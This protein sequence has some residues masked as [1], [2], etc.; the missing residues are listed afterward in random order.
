MENGFYYDFDVEQP[1]TPEDV[2]R[3]EAR[4]RKIIKERQTFTRRVVSEDEARESWPKQPYKLEV[5]ISRA[6][7][8][9]A[10]SEVSDE[11]AV[12]VGGPSSP[13]T[14]TGPAQRQL[15]GR[16]CAAVRTCPTTRIPAFKLMR[17][18]AR[19]G[20]ATSRTRCCSASTAP[21]GSPRRRWRSTCTCWQEA[22]RRD[23]RRLGT[24]LD[25]FSFPTGDRLRP[26][27]C[28]IPRAASSAG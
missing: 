2:E 17:T 12:E 23:H 7:S 13:C 14:T 21:P 11:E 25:L 28:S 5:A 27:R 4:M 18:A 9:G 16:T 1:F 26:A 8:A 10:A 19:T 22:E 3:I 6:A 15:P 20:A 24:E